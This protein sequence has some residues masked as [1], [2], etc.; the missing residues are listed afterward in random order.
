[1]Y[2]YVITQTIIV[3]AADIILCSRKGVFS[4]LGVMLDSFC[5][6]AAWTRVIVYF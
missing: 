6:A 3:D 2:C 1:M 4:V 5:W